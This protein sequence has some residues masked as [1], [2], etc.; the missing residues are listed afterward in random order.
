MWNTGV[1]MGFPSPLR[2]VASFEVFL[3]LSLKKLFHLHKQTNP[4]HHPSVPT[5]SGPDKLPSLVGTKC[6]AADTHDRGLAANT[7]R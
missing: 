1:F 2:A 6:W 5:W 3:E 4:G 7:Y